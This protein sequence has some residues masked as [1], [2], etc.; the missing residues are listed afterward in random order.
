MILHGVDWV[1]IFGYFLLSLIVGVAYSK[2]AGS[3]T[4]EFF[5]SGRNM[6]WWLLGISMVATTFSADTPN[7]VT[8]IV[9]NNGVAGNWLWWAFL[10]TGMLTVFIYSKLWRRSNVMTDIEFYELRYSGKPAAFLRGFRAVYLGFFYNI[11]V[12]AAV[13]LAMIKICGVILKLS[14]VQTLIVAIV[15]T[16]VYSSLGGLFGVL[17]TDLVQFVIAMAGAIWAAIYVVKLPQVGGLAK[18]LTHPNLSGKLSLLPDFSK[19]DLAIAVFFFPLIIQWWNVWYPGAEPGGGGYI[20]QRMLAAKNEKHAMGSTFLFNVLHYALRPWPWIFVA[21][22]SLVVFP[23]LEALQAAFPHINPSIMKH[24]L[25]YPA[26]MTFLPRGLIGMVVASLFAAYMSTIATHL[27]W[28]SSYMVNDFYKRFMK[29]DAPEKRLVMIGRISTFG[30]MLCSSLLALLLQHALE[31][32]QILLLVGAGTGLIFIL[33]WFW[34]RINAYSELTAMV[35]SFIIAL[36][37][38]LVHTRLG[39][40]PLADWQQLLIGIVITTISWITVTLLT[41]PTDEDRLRKYYRLVHPGGPGWKHIMEKEKAAGMLMGAAAEP[42]DVPVGIL[43][44]M[45]GCMAVWGTLFAV[46]YWIYGN[47][48]PAAILTLV[49]AISG[50]ILVRLWR[51]LKTT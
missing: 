22:A 50:F 32:F 41:Q 33:R 18:L 19:L 45:V 28:G 11:I 47:Y 15:I 24:D 25:A 51:K 26:M 35:V 37:F 7:L 23:N 31:A 48:A 44:I 8:D 16:T 14:P 20:A 12:M 6:P 49:A 39:F 30:L 40:E 13:T 27:N 21:L 46:G 9:R 5:L 4:S 38:K 29:C 1:I 34:W 17:L 2:K 10:F 42:W 43:C 36:Y 3:S